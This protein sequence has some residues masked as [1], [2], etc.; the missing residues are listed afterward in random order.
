MS[1]TQ[2][3]RSTQPPESARPVADVAA[4]SHD[5][6]HLDRVHELE[7]TVAR[8]RRNGRKTTRRLHATMLSDLQEAEQRA[9]R[10][11]RRAADAERR[12]HRVR[13]RAEQAESELARVRASTT[14]K[15]GRALVA[16]P[17]RVAA[18]LERRVR[19]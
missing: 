19:R 12:L 13:R 10:A 15:A 1:P 6:A 16:L 3:P 4:P 7:R 17:A 18:R 2:P 14:W 5:E 9:E 8:L 11:Q